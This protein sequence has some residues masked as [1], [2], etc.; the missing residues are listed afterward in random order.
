MNDT[1]QICTRCIVDTT[2]PGAVFDSNGVC[3]YCH[4]H[5]KMEKDFPN[6]ARGEIF[7]LKLA[8]KIKKQNINNKYDCVAGISGG[9]DS[10][11]SLHYI[12]KKMGL[13]PL[14]VHFN[15]GFGNP[16]AGENMIKVCNKLGVEL[17]TITSDWR[18]SKDIKLAFLKAGTPDMEEGTDIGIATAL[19]GMAAKEGLTHILIGQSFR[20]EGIAP[21]T[22]N[23]LDGKY[24][25]AVHKQFGTTSLRK[26]KPDDPGFNLGIKEMF[27]YTILRKIKTIPTLYYVDY[28]RKNVDEFLKAELE[29]QDPGAHYFD[30]LYQSLM[31]YVHRVKFGINR[32]K[33][34]YSALVRS[35]QMAREEAIERAAAP[36]SIED[37]KI[38]DLCIK[39][40]GLKKEEFEKIVANPPKTFMDYPNSYGL[41]KLLRPFI[42]IMAKMNFLPESAYDKYFNCGK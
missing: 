17:R 26:W 6:D 33:F 23:F 37:P 38:I 36:Y 3:S 39:R 4:L 24:L 7:L 16:V 30:D 12:V 1:Y 31:T 34:N 35:G 27:Y 25:K 32:R 9:R 19:Y 8:N 18:E 41:I 21:L 14:A 22:W 5:D 10:T 40:L 29:W 15:D 11:F 2:V 28:V 20:T 42:Y 13:R